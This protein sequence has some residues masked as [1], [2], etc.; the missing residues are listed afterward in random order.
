MQSQ[1]SL[2]TKETMEEKPSTSASYI[3]SSDVKE[4]PKDKHQEN[5]FKCALCNLNEKFEYFGRNPPFL[6]NYQLLEDA[7]V[8]V[9]PF[10]PPNQNQILILG[11][12][13]IH[14]KKMVCKD[15]HCSIY[16]EGTHCI[17]CAKL[18]MNN[19]PVTIQDKI[20]RNLK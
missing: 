1:N 19:F 2:S 11:S 9:D 10:H 7:Y 18:H 16:F 17:K 5:I 20:K 4:N 12:Y 3:E 6:K 13:C 8:I 15:M 14:C